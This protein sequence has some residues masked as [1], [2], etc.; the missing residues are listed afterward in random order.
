MNRPG[1]GPCLAK[2]RV[3]TMKR[4]KSAMTFG[5]FIAGAYRAWGERRAKGRIA[6][7]VNARLVEFRGP[8]CLVMSEV[9]DEDSSFKAITQ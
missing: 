6:M 1:I 3:M 7:I 9:Q 2:E 4:K 5:D 8:Q